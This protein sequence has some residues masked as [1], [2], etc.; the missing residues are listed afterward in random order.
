MWLKQTLDRRLFSTFY[1]YTQQE[2]SNQPLMETKILV[3]SNRTVESE[4][5]GEIFP[6][7]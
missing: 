7:Y 6:Y 3:T 5:P 4:W 1:A 2:T